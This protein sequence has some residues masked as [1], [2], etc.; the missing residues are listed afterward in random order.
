MRRLRTYF[1]KKNFNYKNY[2]NKFNK[3]AKKKTET[4]KKLHK[5]FNKTKLV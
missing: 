5:I 4:K 2:K 1:I 3:W